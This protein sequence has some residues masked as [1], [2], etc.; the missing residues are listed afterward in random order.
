MLNGYVDPN[1]TSDTT[2]WFEWGTTANFGNTTTILSQ[3]NAASNFSASVGGLASN[4]TYYYRA[5]AQ[6]AQGTV[7][8]NTLA[9][10][11]SYV[12]N[13]NTGTGVAPSV[14]TLLGTEITKTSAKLNG[15]IFTSSSQSSNAWF[16]WG[17]N[18]NLSNKTQTFNVGSLPSV[19]HSDFITGLVNGQTYYYRVVAENSYG[20]AYGMIMSF[21][22]ED[23]SST[24]NDTTVV[25]N[26]PG[27]NT[28]TTRNITIINR[29]GAAL[30]LVSLAVDGGADTITPGE[31]RAYHITWKN[32]ST[33][34][35]KNVVLRV[36]LPQSMNFESATRG[37]FSGGDNTV[38]VDIKSLESGETGE[39]FLYAVSDRNLKTGELVIVTANMV[40]TDT[41][42]VQGDAVA[43]MVHHGVLA[44]NIL[45]AS[46]FGAGTF[47]PTT[48]FEWLTLLILILI[49]ILLGNHLYGRF[50]DEKPVAH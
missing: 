1:G 30:S 35:L 31:R 36:T 23:P 13:T 16:E 22:A 50:S 44:Q 10:T 34:I 19:K 33:Q 43:Y 38:T 25:I 42:G 29:G 9:F 24:N 8:G 6:N 28:N 21:V 18:T 2:R 48:L 15:L 7:Y 32:E 20:K 3:G 14:A 47:L 39:M 41:K 4:T 37:A 40:Y 46:L 17:S 5:I 12:D 49:L 45:G 11:T 26:N 27:R